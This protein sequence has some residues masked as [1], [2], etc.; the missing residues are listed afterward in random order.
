MGQLMGNKR[1]L[2]DRATLKHVIDSIRR[3]ASAGRVGDKAKWLFAALMLLMLAVNGLNVAGSYVGRDFMTA[4]EDRNRAQFLFL[5]VLYA[6][7]FAVTTVAA[8]IFRYTEERLGLL[9]REWVTRQSILAYGTN[10]VYYRLKA[11]G[12]IENPDQRISEDIRTYTTTSLSFLL[13]VLN[14]TFSVIAFSGV[15]WS[16]SPRLFIVAILYA[17]AGS[18]LMFLFGRPLVRLNYDQ[19]DKEAN[20]RSSLTYLRANA[21]SVALA[22]REGDVIRLG[23]LHL[24]GLIENFRRIIQVNRRANSCAIGYAY[25]I[26]LIPAVLVAPL[27]IDGKVQFGVITQSAIAFTQLTGAFSLII[28]QFQLISSY[29]AVIAR[30]SDMFH[31]GDREALAERSSAAYR[32][33]E[34]RVAYRGLTL[35]SPRTGRVLVNAMTLDIPR[36]TNVLVQGIDD[37]ARAA[38]FNA[39][40]GLWDIAEGSITRPSLD[41]I[42]FIGELP[43]L[44]PGTLREMLLLPVPELA[45]TDE[46]TLEKLQ[47]DDAKIIDVLQQ[48]EIDSLVTRFGGLD[49]LQHRDKAIPLADQKLLVVARALLA[50][51]VFVYLDRPG[52]AL[53]PGQ[54]ERVLELFRRRAISYVLFEDRGGSLEHFQYLLD[55]SRSGAWNCSRIVGRHIERSSSCA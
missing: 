23:L 39:T 45:E 43:Y 55:L 40:A 44:P 12:E 48:L 22:R 53:A 26:Q 47:A 50:D 4:I 29:T 6:G 52:T 41:K 8:V 36:G 33:D 11:T 7:V 31:S 9:W 46:R 21:E 35:L 24:T 30:L 32:R 16:I 27:F 10:R 54:I 17:A 42:M 25:L 20:L 18:Y 38:L 28:N 34:S 14:S 37:G 3:F 49:A 2:L 19:L 1:V 13:M 5:I 51:P 15:M